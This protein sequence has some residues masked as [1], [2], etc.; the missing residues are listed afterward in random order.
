VT[1]QVGDT[2]VKVMSASGKPVCVALTTPQTGDKVITLPTISGKNVTVKLTSPSIG[3]DVVICTTTSGKMVAIKTASILETHLTDIEHCGNGVLIT[4][5]LVSGKFYRSADN[6]ATW[7]RYSLYG[8][9][10]TAP[11]ARFNAFLSLGGGVVLAG[12]AATSPLGEFQMWKSTDYGLTWEYKQTLELV[13]KT[14]EAGCVEIVRDKLVTTRLYT[15]SYNQGVIYKSE[16]SGNTWSQVYYFGVGATNEV[17]S[18][19]AMANGEKFCSTSNIDGK[20]WISRDNCASWVA[21]PV[22]S[23]SSY[24]YERFDAM[25]NTANDALITWSG[26]LYVLPP[27][28]QYEIDVFVGP[29][30]TTCY[31]CY[32]SHEEYLPGHIPDE[33]CFQIAFDPNS[34][35]T[36]GSFGSSTQQMGWGVYM[37][38]NRCWTHYWQEYIAANNFYVTKVFTSSEGSGSSVCFSTETG[39]WYMCLGG[40]IWWSADHGKNWTH[41]VDLSY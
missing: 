12:S 15:Y 26:K 33:T 23:Y 27:T 32:W 36:V 28:Y 13:D 38:N 39:K 8:F 4:C 6:G 10:L 7:A 18:F 34:M 1:V 22:W 21:G 24:A 16:D 25:A 35:S 5:G 29:A 11:Y 3:D 30:L 14:Y 41:L 17:L 20:T 31:G 2:I 40:Q 19:V 9:G 37:N